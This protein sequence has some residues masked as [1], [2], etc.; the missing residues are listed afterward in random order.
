MS[1]AAGVR[2]LTSDLAELIGLLR[3]LIC[4]LR[5]SLSWTVLVIRV[6]THVLD[7]QSLGFLH[8]W[9]LFCFGEHLPKL[10]QP[11][12]YLSVMHVGIL[13]RDLLPL[14]LRPYHESIHRPFNVSFLPSSR[15]LPFLQKHILARVQ[16]RL[17]LQ[18]CIGNGN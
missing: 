10:S 2:R 18:G 15:S 16:H 8:K 6:Q 12:A 3:L 17:V 7:A 13:H 14:Y 5:A 11:P 1:F 4:L 9:L